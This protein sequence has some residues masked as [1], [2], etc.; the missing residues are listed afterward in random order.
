MSLLSG[1]F[2]Y[3]LDEAWGEKVY[4]IFGGGHGKAP[5]FGPALYT[6]DFKEYEFYL[7]FNGGVDFRCRHFAFRWAALSLLVADTPAGSQLC[8]CNPAGVCVPSTAINRD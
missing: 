1:S 4:F 2:V 5:E 3:F 7:I 6:I 8:R